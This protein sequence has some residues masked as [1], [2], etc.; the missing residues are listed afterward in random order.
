MT[1]KEINPIPSSQWF[2]GHRN[3]TLLIAVFFLFISAVTFFLSYRHYQQIKGH[4]LQDDRNAAAHCARLIEVH[5]HDMTSTMESYANRPLL[6]RAAAEKNTVRAREHLMNLTRLNPPIDSVSIT[7]HGGTLWIAEPH[8][9]EAMG[10]NFAHRD[11]YQGVIKTWAPYV[12]EAASRFAG[13][14]EPVIE[15]AVPII[16]KKK[17]HIGIL[18]NTERTVEIGRMI[19]LV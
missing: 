15:I 13:E 6:I 5:L 17:N 14:K 16:D 12:S 2:A 4:I 1:R 19:K 18:V 7:D 10:K 11:W 9:P 3:I 8:R